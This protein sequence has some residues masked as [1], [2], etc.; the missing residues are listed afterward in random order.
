MHHARHTSGASRA[1]QR[2][3]GAPEASTA[4]C[5]A[6]TARNSTRRNARALDGPGCSTACDR[7]AGSRHNSDAD[8]A[9]SRRSSAAIK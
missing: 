6:S 3:V 2:G 7:G 9:T 8:A 1:R 5:R 4:G